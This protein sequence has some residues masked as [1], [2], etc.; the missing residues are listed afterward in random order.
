MT[1]TSTNPVTNFV[2]ELESF[3]KN[4]AT[5]VENFAAQM[6]PKVEA[7]LEVALEDLATIAG[8]AVLAQLPLAI[9][10]QE[11]FGAAVA[12]VVQTVEASGKTIAISTA[13]AVVQIAALTA[14]NVA[15]G[16]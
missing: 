4:A 2:T 6:L 8:Q 1:T 12:N 13:Q 11:K 9:S 10:G 16:K 15:A 3:F 14:Q 7:V 5:K